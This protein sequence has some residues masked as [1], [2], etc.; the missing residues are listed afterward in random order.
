M[1]GHSLR[2]ELFDSPSVD[3]ARVGGDGIDG[4]TTRLAAYEDGY[5]AGWDDATR[6]QNELQS[7]VTTDLAGHLQDLAFTFHE[8]RAHVLAGVSPMLMDVLGQLLPAM[9]KAAFPAL[10]AE[11]LQSIIDEASN[12]PITLVISPESREALLSVLPAD[13]GFPLTVREE[14]TLASGQV[15]LR[16][17]GRETEIDID[18]VADELLSA[19]RDF[20][21]DNEERIAVHG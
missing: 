15:F 3:N 6:S 12:A 13:P 1:S 19:T 5:K 7:T 2:L 17:E 21:A 10:V 18:R 8:A 14:T 4:E 11:K 20:F 16:F 9:A